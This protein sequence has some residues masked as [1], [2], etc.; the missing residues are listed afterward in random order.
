MK[1]E[2]DKANKEHTK[3]E[4][5]RIIVGLFIMVSM[6]L[7]LFSWDI[8]NAIKEKTVYCHFENKYH[9]DVPRI[10][11]LNMKIVSIGEYNTSQFDSL[12]STYSCS[13]N[14]KDLP[15]CSYDMT[16]KQNSSLKVGYYLN[17]YPLDLF[18][19][20][21]S[22]EGYTCLE[23]IIKYYT[24]DTNRIWQ[25]E[26]MAYQYQFNDSLKLKEGFIRCNSEVR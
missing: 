12:N 23:Y 22:V 26:E 25:F 3:I 16:T 11:C 19:K 10:E 20:N 18:C 2:Q 14:I 17:Y 24:V 13:K 5:G 4:W 6:L 9:D 15:E 1:P 21:C 7:I 8:R